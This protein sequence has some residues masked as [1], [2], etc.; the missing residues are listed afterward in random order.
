MYPHTI[1]PPMSF[2]YPTGDTELLL[3]GVDGEIPD[4]VEPALLCADDIH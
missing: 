2:L 1:F 3:E 4:T